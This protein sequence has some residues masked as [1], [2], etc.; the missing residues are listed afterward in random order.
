MSTVETFFC[1]RLPKSLEDGGEILPDADEIKHIG[2]KRYT[3]GDQ[4]EF[5]DGHGN[6]ALCCVVQKNPFQFEL[7][8]LQRDV[9][10]HT[11]T[12]VLAVLK[13]DAFDL[14]IQMAVELGVTH[15]IFWGA[16]RSIAKLDVN[17]EKVKR[18]LELKI[19]EACKQTRRSIFPTFEFASSKTL[20]AVLGQDSTPTVCY[21]HATE[22]LSKRA[23]GGSAGDRDVLIVGPEG[24]ITDE[25]VEM[26]KDMGADFV[27]LGDHILKAPTAVACALSQ[28][29][30]D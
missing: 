25:E 29:V 20:R 13:G 9:N 7:V 14:A 5:V 1:R 24:G 30:L 15:F 28:L 21:E 4:I 8:D 6:R 23:G 10:K 11:I 17:D 3:I 22:L 27:S 12:L 19:K 16:N 26:F 18:K 2:I